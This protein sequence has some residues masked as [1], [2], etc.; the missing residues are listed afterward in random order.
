VYPPI[1]L[2]FITAHF[3]L[4]IIH[5]LPSTARSFITQGSFLA[6]AFLIVLASSTAVEFSSPFGLSD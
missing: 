4:G 3:A 1:P 5:F 6:L 2:N